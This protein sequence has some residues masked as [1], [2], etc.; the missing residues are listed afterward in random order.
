M[1]ISFAEKYP[2]ENWYQQ[3][4]NSKTVEECG[5][6]KKIL[7]DGIQEDVAAEWANYHAYFEALHVPEAIEWVN[8]GGDIFEWSK[9]HWML[10]YAED[11]PRTE[12]EE[13]IKN[14]P[15]KKRFVHIGCGALPFTG[16]FFSRYFEKICL[17]DFDKDACDMARDLF[18][19]LKIYNVEIFHMNGKDFPLHSD[20]TLL[21]ASMVLNKPEIVA[22]ASEKN[23]KNIFL[24]STDGRPRGI[25]CQKDHVISE[26]YN[27]IYTG[28]TFPPQE[29]SNVTYQ[30]IYSQ[31]M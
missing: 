4:L 30:Y 2:F 21:I 16:I 23:V 25:F 9:T 27:Y 10:N 3:T 24:R 14:I 18:K 29:I 7:D 17:V 13:L 19:A 11:L 31:R 8:N 26:E 22:A 5:I 6:C 12:Y 15:A 20:D 1:N 28:R